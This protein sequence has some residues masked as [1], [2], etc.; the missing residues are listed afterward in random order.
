MPYDSQTQSHGPELRSGADTPERGPSPQDSAKADSAGGLAQ[1]NGRSTSSQTL[2]PVITDRPEPARPLPPD[3]AL[4]QVKALQRLSGRWLIAGVISLATVGAIGAGVWGV[5]QLQAA[6]KPAIDLS[7]FTVEAKASDLTVTIDATGTIRPVQTVNLSPKT[8][9]R[10]A[11][12]YVQQGDYVQAGQVIAKMDDSEVRV[13][14]AQARAAVSRAEARLA[15][16]INGNRPEE[17]A[18]AKARFDRARADVANSQARLSQLQ[19]GNRP[20]EIAEAEARITRAKADLLSA[21]ARLS[22]ATARLQRNQTLADEGAIA[23]DTLD[24]ARQE[25]RT[26]RADIERAQAQVNE[27]QKAADRIRSGSRPQEVD[28]GRADLA[29][30]QAA[31]NEAQQALQRIRNGSRP[32]EIQSARADVA[33]ARANLALVQTQL[34]DT[35]VRAPFAGFISQKYA[36]VGAFVTPTTSASTGSGATSTSIAALGRDLEVLV[37]VPEVDIGQIRLGQAVEVVA[38]AYPDRVFKGRVKLIAPEAVRDRDVTSFEIRAT[39]LEGLDVLKSGMNANMTLLGDRISNAL[40]VP[41]VAVVTVK[42]RKGVLVPDENQEPTFRP[43]TAG[44]TIG[45]R[46]QI[47]QGLKSGDRVFTNLPPGKKLE[48]IAAPKG[49]N[50]QHRRPS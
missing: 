26:A 24:A 8:S 19:V 3:P 41:T 33:E 44:P 14:L 22:L 2:A 31:A 42:G 32:E 1:N 29:R 50:G 37:R 47:L 38:D 48:D 39:L 43:V 13:R 40:V 46:I 5:S 35:V 36:E 34:E 12:L 28:A 30:V 20:Q 7:Q 18:E 11:A 25:E 45:D 27:T 15:Q 21:Q 16:L 23:R 6:R 10:L 9:G 17:I 4:T 49:K